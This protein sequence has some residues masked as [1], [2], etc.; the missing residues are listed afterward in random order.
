MI[1]EAISLLGFCLFVFVLCLLISIKNR[2]FVSVFSHN[3]TI[4]QADTYNWDQ[5][6]S[7]KENMETEKK[8]ILSTA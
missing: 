6:T 4:T 1:A 8:K 5:N 7:G 2:R 3:A